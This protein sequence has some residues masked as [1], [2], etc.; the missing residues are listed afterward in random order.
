MTTETFYA[1]FDGDRAIALF[2]TPEQ[3]ASFLYWHY[4][5][6]VPYSIVPWEMDPKEWEAEE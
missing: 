1:A 3:A 5:P 2:R 6:D 4:R